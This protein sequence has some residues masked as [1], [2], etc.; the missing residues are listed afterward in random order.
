MKKLL[1]HPTAL[2][3]TI[4]TTSAAFLSKTNSFSSFAAAAVSVVESESLAETGGEEHISIIIRDKDFLRRSYKSISGL[5]VLDLIDN[6]SLEP[7]TGIYSHLLWSCTQLKKLEEGRLV[8]SHFLASKFKS[9]IFFQ[10]SIINF[11][12]KCN[13]L[14]EARK[15]FDQMPLRDVVS[16]TALLS[17]YTQNDKPKEALA[18]FPRMLWSECKPNNF[19]FATLLNACGAAVEVETGMQIHASCVKTGC[20]LDVYVGS[21]LLDMYT[22]HGK[23]R[24]AFAAFD[25][26]DTKNEVSWNALIAGFARKED[27]NS[28]IKMFVD[29]QRLGFPAT[30]FTYSGIFSACASN[31]SLEQGKWV[32]AH[33][34]KHGHK[35]NVFVGNTL[36]DMYAKAGS[37][38][39]ARKVFCRLDKNDIVSWNSMLTGCAQHGLGHEAVNRFEMMLKH[40][41]MPNQITFLCILNACSHGG[42]LKEWEYYFNLMKEYMVEPEIEHFVAIVDLLGRAGLLERAWKFIDEMPLKPTAAVW[43]ALLGGALLGACRLHK[44]VELGKLVAERVFELDPHDAG[45]RLL[46]YNIYASASRWNDA[47]KVRKLMRES[48][49]KKEPACSWV[50]VENSVHL[51]VANENCHPQIKEIEQMWEKING[52]IK[53]EGYV[54]DI[55]YVLMHVDEQEKEA[56]LKYH[57]EKL[58]LAFAL[59]KLP[60]GA[61]IRIKKN[62]RICGD[63]HP[64]IKL[65]SKVIKREIIIRDAHRFHHFSAGKCSCGDYW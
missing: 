9:D 33:M 16:W 19:T 48:G 38:E 46:L 25:R 2:S 32:H 37:I 5:H 65:V 15:A 26:L 57:S 52:R 41:V 21:S 53:E 61:T 42:L 34:I 27:L 22:R 58:A 54:P 60:S 39:D 3:A 10:N 13:S 18:L 36:L 49:L 56:K 24:E 31:G 63:C 1:L 45:P 55:N 11:Y 64:A 50:E 30:H 4:T 43:G 28:A 20:D 59:L 29:M 35:L 7:S 14:D 44:N 62:I 40:G 8:H 12:S 47:A 6:G 17:G 23:M 51:F